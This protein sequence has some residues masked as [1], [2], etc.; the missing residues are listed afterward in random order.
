MSFFSFF[1]ALI[2][3]FC[4]LVCVCVCVWDVRSFHWAA[5]GKRR[6]RIRQTL[7]GS[8]KTWFLSYFEGIGEFLPT[9]QGKMTNRSISMIV[10]TFFQLDSLS[11]GQPL[12]EEQLFGTRFSLY[13]SLFF[14]VLRQVDA[15]VAAVGDTFKNSSQERK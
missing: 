14:L 6:E 15:A 4:F 10:K 13:F 7:E 12:F 9:V 8:K 3:S 5:G 2:F 11:C 1:L